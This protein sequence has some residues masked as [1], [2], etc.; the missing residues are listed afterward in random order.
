MVKN[1]LFGLLV[2]VAMVGCNQ[3]DDDDDGSKKTFLENY[4]GVF[5]YWQDEKHLDKQGGVRFYNDSTKILQYFDLTYPTADC[6]YM[7]GLN[8]I[9]N[10]DG[11]EYFILENSDDKFVLQFI[12][13]EHPEG[14][15]F[16]PYEVIG[17]NKDTLRYGVP[18]SYTYFVRD[19][20]SPDTFDF[21][22]E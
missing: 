10:S 4:E 18:E 17:K 11:G 2:V 13:S 14:Y 20:I 3:D 5:W 8:M 1:I 7:T 9:S 15:H 19:K 6:W 21:C 22:N 16:Y 12:D